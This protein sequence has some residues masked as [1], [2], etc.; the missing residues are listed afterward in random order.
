[1]RKCPRSLSLIEFG[2][3]F[4]RNFCVNSFFRSRILKILLLLLEM[5]GTS[6]QDFEVKN[7][8]VSLSTL[9]MSPL[10]YR[11]AKPRPVSRSPVL[12]Y[13]SRSAPGP[14]YRPITQGSVVRSIFEKILCCHTYIKCET[15]CFIFQGT[16]QRIIYLILVSM[17]L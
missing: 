8:F 3:S 16:L 4:D 13:R 9:K 10:E 15:L 7:P 6:H 2:D 12:S 5:S 11:K 14:I 17:N 1:M